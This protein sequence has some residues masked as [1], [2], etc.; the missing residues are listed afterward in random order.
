MLTTGYGI[1]GGINITMVF[2]LCGQY[3][4][5]Y[6]SLKN[7]NHLV[8]GSDSK[9]FHLQK[10]YDF[11]DQ[12]INQYFISTEKFEKPGES[13]KASSLKEALADCAKHHQIIL[14]FAKLLQDFFGWF[15]FSKLIY[16]GI[17]NIRSRIFHI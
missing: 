10:N 11:D 9:T 15:V 2:M 7:L 13:I 5:L 8:D 12:E 3:D 16:S 1:C 17:K 4:I 6:A 14:E